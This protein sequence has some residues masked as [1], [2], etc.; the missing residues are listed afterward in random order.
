MV[1]QPQHFFSD[2]G[3]IIRMNATVQDLLSLPDDGC[4]YEMIMGVIVQMPPAQ[5]NHGRV[6]TFLNAALIPYCLT[7]GILEN[8]LAE[9]GYQI[10]GSN[11]V[12]APDL[13][14]I[15]TPCKPGETF[16]SFPPLL[17]VEIASPSQGRPFLK[18]KARAFIAAGTQMVWV[19]WQDTK[20]VDVYTASDIISLGIKDILDGGSVFPGLVIPVGDIFP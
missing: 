2:N 10:F 15:Q 19:F 14:I 9:V 16:S 20:T 8:L 12:L 18:D 4:R 7:H 17:A 1:A 13:S 6:I 11:T 3:T 5:E